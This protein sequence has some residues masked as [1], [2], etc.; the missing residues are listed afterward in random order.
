MPDDGLQLLL[1]LP[2]EL[3]LNRSKK[4]IGNNK[5]EKEKMKHFYQRKVDGKP[6][7]TIKVKNRA[8]IITNHIV[9]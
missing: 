1:Q 6:V 5:K 9:L 8:A 4:N 3:L 7:S 2:D